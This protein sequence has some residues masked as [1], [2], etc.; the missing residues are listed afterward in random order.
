MHVGN[1]NLG[2][3]KCLDFFSYFYGAVK[4]LVVCIL[5]MSLFL[6][7]DPGTVSSLVAGNHAQCFC[8]T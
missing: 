1:R 6:Q 3:G 2:Y 8:S 4:K 5:N 7:H